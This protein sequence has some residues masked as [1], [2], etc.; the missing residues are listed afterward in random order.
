MQWFRGFVG[1]WTLRPLT[2]R[3]HASWGLVCMCVS[4]N[5]PGGLY[6]CISEEKAVVLAG[7]HA[8]GTS[9]RLQRGTTN[10]RHIEL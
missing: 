2:Q 7:P 4:E 10:S 9:A 3:G 6:Y 5:S 8:A 1:H